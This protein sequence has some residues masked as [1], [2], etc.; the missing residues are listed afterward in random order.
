MK[1]SQGKH[2]KIN[3]GLLILFAW[4][5]LSLFIQLAF[6]NYFIECTIQK[7]ILSKINENFKL[8]ILPIDIC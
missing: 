1:D 7:Q 8:D 2:S 6:V 5:C 4:K 3:M